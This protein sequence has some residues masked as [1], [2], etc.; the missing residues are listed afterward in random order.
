MV[1][2][3]EKQGRI[4]DLW[5]LVAEFDRAVAQNSSCPKVE[6]LVLVNF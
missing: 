5:G 4:F 1:R 3:E 2:S 6:G